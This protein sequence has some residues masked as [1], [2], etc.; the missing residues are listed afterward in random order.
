MEERPATGSRVGDDIGVR[1]RGRI[2]A[3]QLPG[4]DPGIVGILFMTEIIVGTITVAIWAGEPF[5]AREIIGVVLI[6]GAGLAESLQAPFSWRW[7]RA[8]TGDR[9]SARGSR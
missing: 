6:S 1:G 2:G 4:V 3:S 7:Q 9:G 8:K 5:G